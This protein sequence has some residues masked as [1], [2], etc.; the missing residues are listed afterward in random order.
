MKSAVILRIRQVTLKGRPRTWYEFAP[1]V[2]DRPIR[3][4]DHMMASAES[5]ARR[6][7]QHGF[8]IDH[9]MLD[10]TV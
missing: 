2:N 5:A 9:E 3:R 1:L 6:A 4:Q 8:D 7:R 10:F